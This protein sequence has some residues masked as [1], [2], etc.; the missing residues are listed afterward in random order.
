MA[1]ASARAFPLRRGALGAAGGGAY[2]AAFGARVPASR[3]F[4]YPSNNGNG[5]GGTTSTAAAPKDRAGAANAKGPA[6]A[7]AVS[8]AKTKHAEQVTELIFAPFDELKK[9]LEELRESEGRDVQL[10]REEGYTQQLEDAVNHQINVELTIRCVAAPRALAQRVCRACVALLCARIAA[11]HMRHG[12][13]SAATSTTACTP[14]STATTWRCVAWPSTSARCLRRS[15][16]TP[17]G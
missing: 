7:A 16:S 2:R 17:R 1:L 15:G 3:L 12:P 8:A 4:A 13:L 10:A 9:P 11:P 5:R 6:P 14:I